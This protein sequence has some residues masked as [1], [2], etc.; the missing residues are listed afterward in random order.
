[1]DGLLDFIINESKILMLS[2]ILQNTLITEF[3]RRF[4]EEYA[5]ELGTSPDTKLLTNGSN[6]MWSGNANNPTNN[7]ILNNNNNKNYSFTSELIFK[8]I[9][10]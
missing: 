6:Q 4:K 2:T 10:K 8:L 7:S 5:R 9:S 1:L 3:S